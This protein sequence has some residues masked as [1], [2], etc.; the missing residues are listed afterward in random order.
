MRGPEGPDD[1]DGSDL[2]TTWQALYASLSKFTSARNA[3]RGANLTLCC[4]LDAARRRKG[5]AALFDEVEVIADQLGK[6][7]RLSEDARVASWKILEALP[8]AAD[9]QASLDAWIEHFQGADAG[10]KSLG[11]YATPSVFADALADAALDPL[12]DGAS[13]PAVIDP[14][15][16]AGSLLLAAHQR[17]VASGTD[18]KEAVRCLHGVEVDPLSRELCVLLLWVA[19]GWGETELDTIAKNVRLANALTHDWRGEGRFDAVLM[20]P[21]WESLRH[22]RADPVLARARTE[23][24]ARLEQRRPVADGLPPLFSAQGRGDRNL[25]K[26]F[27]ELVPHLLRDGGRLG[28]LLP[29]AFGSDDGMA[30]LRALYLERFALERWTGFEN[31]ARH[32]RI[33]SRYKFGLLTGTRSDAGTSVL[34]ILAFGTEPRDIRRPHVLLSRSDLSRIGGPD[35]MIPELVSSCERDIV[36]RALDSGTGLF[37]PG[38]L[39]RVGYRREVD[40]TLGRAQGRFWPVGAHPAGGYPET[41][42]LPLAF[43][44]ALV[45]VVEGRMIGPY[46]CFQKSWV[47]GWGRRAVWQENGARPIEDCQPQ[48]V[49]LRGRSQQHRVAICDVTS[50]TNTR[51]VLAALV[52]DGWVCGNTAPV[53]TFETET[54]ALAGLG[55]L[56]SMVFDWIT[57]RI[58]GGLHLNR[59]YLACLTWPALDADAVFLLADRAR[60]IATAHPRGGRGSAKDKIPREVMVDNLAAI[61][62]AVAAGFGLDHSMLEQIYNPDTNDRRGLWRYLRADS[63]GSEIATKAITHHRLTLLAAE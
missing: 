49:A 26:M 63:V 17:L 40:L 10:R 2:G 15:A 12:L 45:P 60:R 51:T 44:D 28:A 1:R 42:A 31:R 24:L 59:F 43:D 8:A 46:D 50:A 52:P 56:N 22:E 14:A 37:T 38:P 54:A 6:P 16:G 29:A 61:E 3:R 41:E 53:L 7:L 27:I 57:R 11:A 58:V 20:N 5:S 25:A 36:R 62:A 13:T 39:G 35:R 18:P 21:P 33:D 34:S 48:Y 4:G 32:F 30:A 19:A 55:V 9:A 23:T 47:T